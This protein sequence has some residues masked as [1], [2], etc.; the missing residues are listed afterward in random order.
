M[1]EKLN[2]FLKDVYEKLTDA[3]KEKMKNCKSE[4]EFMA[5]LGE[6]GIELPDDVLDAVSGGLGWTGLG[7]DHPWFSIRRG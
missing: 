2:A 6:V 1:N 5:F 7:G 4:E 3:Q